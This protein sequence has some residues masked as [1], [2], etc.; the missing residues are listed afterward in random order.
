MTI[1]GVLIVDI[2]EGR[3]H[4]CVCGETFNTSISD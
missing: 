3:T 4:V 2:G 1:S